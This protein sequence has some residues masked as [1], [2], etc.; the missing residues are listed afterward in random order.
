MTRSRPAHAQHASP[1]TPPPNASTSPQ[2]TDDRGPGGNGVHAFSTMAGAYPGGVLVV[3][4]NMVP[5]G[6]ILGQ[7][8]APQ[9][10]EPDEPLY[11]NAKQS[12]LTT[13]FLILPE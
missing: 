3:D 7:V 8:A 2:P 5:P 4:P 1:T 12:A 11:V 10:E 13:S 9:V 6:Y